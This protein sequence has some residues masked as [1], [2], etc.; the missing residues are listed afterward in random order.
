MKLPPFRQVRLLLVGLMLAPAAATGAET[1]A[2]PPRPAVAFELKDQF[3]VPH[4]M[5][6]PRTRLTVLAVADRKGSEQVGGWIAPIRERY[7]ADL[8]IVGLAD[9]GKVPFFL[10]GTVQGRFRKD[11]AHPVMLDWSG[12]VAKRFGYEADAASLLILHRDGTVLLRFSGAANEERL[13]RVFETIDRALGQPADGLSSPSSSG[14][15]A[16]KPPSGR[17]KSEAQA[18]SASPSTVL[19]RRT[20]GPL[21]HFAEEREL[22]TLSSRSRSDGIFLEQSDLVSPPAMPKGFPWD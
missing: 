7:P 9:L 4:A 21:L 19:L 6:F 17:G 22:I 1:R 5:A 12:Q 8:D 13:R 11:C 15:G 3:D 2:V 10:R 14:D 18:G 20:G 16:A